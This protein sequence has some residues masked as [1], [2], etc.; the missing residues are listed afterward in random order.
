MRCP[1]RPSRPLRKPWTLHWPTRSSR[2][3]TPGPPSI[4]GCLEHEAPRSQVMARHRLFVTGGTGY[5]GCALAPALLARGHEV[6]MLVRAGSERK[7]AAGALNVC[8]DAL[9]AA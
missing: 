6:R 4:S 5:I 7:A 9:S 3:G 2:D 1:G 8:G